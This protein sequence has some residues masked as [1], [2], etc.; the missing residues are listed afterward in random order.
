MT[1]TD[2]IGTAGVSI[3]LLAFLLN[4]FKIIS[5]ASLTYILLNLVGAAIACY[6][7]VLLSY[8]PFIILEGIWMVVSLISLI[9]V[10]RK[11]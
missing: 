6:A 10:L 2:W 7:S 11:R 8:W 9:A 1:F 3:L 4:L 5:Q